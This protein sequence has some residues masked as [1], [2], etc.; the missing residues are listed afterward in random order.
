MKT[1]ILTRIASSILTLFLVISFSFFLFRILP[2]DPA[3]ALTGDPRLPAESKEAVYKM[4]GLD[5]PLL[6]QYLL[7]LVNTIKG[8]LGISFQY[9]TPVFNILM[10]KLVNTLILLIPAT[11]LSIL[12]GVLVGLIAGLYKGK[13]VDNL[14]RSIATLVWSTPSFWAGMLAVYLFAVNIRLFPTGGMLRIGTSF[15]LENIGDLLWHLF[16]PMMVYAIIYSGQYALLVRESLDNVLTE[17]FMMLARAKG[18]SNFKIMTRYALRN[19]LLPLVSLIGINFGNIILGSITIESVFSWP[20]IGRLVYDAI[21]YN[22][23][24]LLQGVF[25]FFSTF[26]IISMVF[27]DILY[28]YLD[29]RIRFR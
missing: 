2:G 13:K 4:F 22:D 19:V 5:K 12:L 11:V 23:Y 28:T 27:I 14:I 20:G 16:L 15:S 21:F 1:Y 17:D 3:T 9:K 26:M 8:N 29:P 18:Y 7:F 10:E 25:L 24:P 6:E